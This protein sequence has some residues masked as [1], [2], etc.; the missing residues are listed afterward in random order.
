M[1]KERLR[2]GH[3][4]VTLQVE[5]RAAAEIQL[6]AELL[7]AYMQAFARRRGCMAWRMSRT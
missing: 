3:V 2:R 5:R 1:L 4:D 7:S 6:N